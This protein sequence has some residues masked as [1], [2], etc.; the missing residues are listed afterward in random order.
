MNRKLS[1]KRSP[2]QVPALHM[3]AILIAAGESQVVLQGA[4]STASGADAQQDCVHNIIS[5][6]AR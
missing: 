2:A 3:R 6:R 5:Y 1:T 4:F